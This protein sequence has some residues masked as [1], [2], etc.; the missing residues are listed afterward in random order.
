MVFGNEMKKSARR[1]V[2]AV[3]SGD[4]MAVEAC[5]A[6]DCRFTDSAGDTI[7]GRSLCGRAVRQLLILEPGY[8]IIVEQYAVHDDEVLMSGHVQAQ[9]HL[10][11]KDR[12]WRARISGGKITE[13]Q[14][15]CDGEARQLVHILTDIMA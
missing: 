6:S 5:L 1:L 7:E 11:A 2:E 15:Y 8:R 13:W 14:S 10:L 4:A 12:L 3:N 9:D